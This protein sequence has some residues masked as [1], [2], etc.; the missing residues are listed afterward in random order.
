[1]PM[2]GANERG[3]QLR[4]PRNDTVTPWAALFP[5]RPTVAFPITA[6][7]VLT[8]TVLFTRAPFP[9][10]LMNDHARLRWIFVGALNVPANEAYT[11]KKRGQ[12]KGRVYALNAHVAAPL[13]RAARP[14]SAH[15]RW[16]RLRR[17]GT[18]S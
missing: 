6:A 12:E 17:P 10:V 8:P 9:G 4:R 5:V 14:S 13:M 3:R 18:G 2:L 15:F 7:L 11:V 16:Q 1:M